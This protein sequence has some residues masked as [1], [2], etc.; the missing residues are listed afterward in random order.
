[1]SDAANQIERL[2]TLRT[3]PAR[4]LSITTLV[5]DIA[6]RTRKT[7]KK[8]GSLIELWEAN[9]PPVLCARTSITGLRGGTMHVAVD[10]AATSYE[11]DRLLREGLE[12]TLRSQYRG[13]LMRVRLKVTPDEIARA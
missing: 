11:L 4:D 6:E 7:H 8:F 5:G 3:R 2:R 13:T 10:S 12:Q 9:V 1:M